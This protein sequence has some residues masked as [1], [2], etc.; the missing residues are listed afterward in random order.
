MAESVK[1]YFGKLFS[2]SNPTI[3]DIDASLDFAYIV[4][5]DHMNEALC[6]P[7]TGEEVRITVFD[8]HPSKAPGPDGFTIFFYQKLWPVIGNDVVKAVL[9]ILNGQKD[10][11]EWNE[12]LIMLIQK[13]R[14]PVYLKDFRPSSLCNM[15]Y[16]MVSR[17]ITN[18][19]RPILD[20]IIDSFQSAFIPRRLIMDNA[21]VSFECMHWIHNNR[22]NKSGFAALKLDMRKAYDHVEWSF[23]QNMMTKMGFAEK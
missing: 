22:K 10:L 21:I 11:T 18:R 15:C 16:K 3:M 19:F 8:M 13:I 2:S 6:A 23:L 1:D 9:S 7:F 14:Y 5:G 20:Q 17:A 12:T 4:V